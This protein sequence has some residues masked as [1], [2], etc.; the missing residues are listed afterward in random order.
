MKTFR[1]LVAATA[2]AL[3]SVHS[4]AQF[5]ESALRQQTNPNV[6]QGLKANAAGDVKAST[7]YF[8]A[9]VKDDPTNAYAH[10]LLA[11]A[12]A[13]NKYDY[14]AYDRAA[15]LFLR[16]AEL[17]PKD[18]FLLSKAYAQI[19]KLVQDNRV[20]DGV[21]ADNQILDKLADACQHLEG[22]DAADGYCTLAEYYF[23]ETRYNHN[24]QL[25]DQ[26]GALVSKALSVWPFSSEAYNTEARRAINTGGTLWALQR[27]SDIDGDRASRL[28]LM[29]AYLV[30]GDM[31]T[32]VSGYLDVYANGGSQTSS[33]A[34][35]SLVYGKPEYFY[36]YLPDDDREKFYLLVDL[37]VRQ[38]M[39]DEPD[40]ENWPA[41]L[42]SLSKERSHKEEAVKYFE[43]AANLNHAFLLELS[44]AKN[45]AGDHQGALAALDS[46]L[47]EF[48]TS[49]YVYSTRAEC[50][51]ECGFPVDSVLADLNRL[52]AL[53]PVAYD[54]RKRAAFEET[55]GL[56]REAIADYFAALQ[57]EPND[58]YS[59]L[60]R[61]EQFQI[62]GEKELA[63]ADFNAALRVFQKRYQ[64]QHPETWALALARLGRVDEVE[65]QILPMNEAS[66]IYEN[67]SRYYTLACV[68]SIARQPDKCLAALKK[69]LDYGFANFKQAR[70]DYDLENIRSDARF[71]SL[72]KQ[73]EAKATD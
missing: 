17:A 42:A 18:Y 37:M 70:T 46:Y 13:K 21:I 59:I 56:H 68:Y 32:A 73:Y 33:R 39:V 45:A 47:A 19:V 54:F 2:L 25:T 72:L 51:A 44:D 10:Y 35:G 26:S 64:P 38:R 55:H 34:Y 66:S 9:A 3:A 14:D 27:A 71:E 36:A 1:I 30:S 58:A 65:K 40:N 41:L 5:T 15:D 6:V 31:N 69:S 22:R 24:K 48:P 63:E 52:V 43:I 11:R 53:S 20:A 28:N 4:S 16:A 60:Q 29:D 12:L 62:L 8:E 67:A 57:Q 7:L 50:R 23:I 49:A 61:G